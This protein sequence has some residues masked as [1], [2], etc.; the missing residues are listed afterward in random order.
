MPSVG[1]YI[2]PLLLGL[3]VISL[4]FQK[5]GD[6]EGILVILTYIGSNTFPYLRYILK[7]ALILSSYFAMG[8]NFASVVLFVLTGI[9][10][11]PSMV[12]LQ[13]YTLRKD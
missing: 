9:I 8:A 4:L 2:T 3:I 10:A 12:L 7:I 1:Y 11:Y 13:N 6:K 5:R